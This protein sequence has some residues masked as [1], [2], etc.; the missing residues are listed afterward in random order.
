MSE[1]LTYF[2]ADLHLGARYIDRP[3]EYERKICA[4]LRQI[5]PTAK[6]IYLVGD[7][8]DYW[9]EYRHVVPQGYVRF[10]GCL[11]ELADSGIEITWLIG[12]HDIW[13]FDY[14]PK[15]LGI[16][17]VDGVLEENIDGQTFVITHG[18]GIGHRPFSERFMRGMF[19][20]K[21]LQTLF[22]SVHPRWTV[23]LAY[24]WSN[25]N[26]QRHSAHTQIDP[27]PLFD[28]VA[29]RN[30]KSEIIPN[31]YIFGHYHLSESKKIA[32]SQITILG[33]WHKNPSY[34]TFNG[35]E[36]EL[37]LL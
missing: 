9:Y 3:K 34:A 21:F 33:D 6:R 5:A 18:D 25:K 8:L 13:I 37:T 31:H 14:L 28:W 36:V 27:Q 20:S 11:A 32:G 17:V 19:R 35:K 15:E 30:K 16:R 10:L 24:W 29:E 22:A 23:G 7:I 4:W 1:K 12:N 26:R 2:I